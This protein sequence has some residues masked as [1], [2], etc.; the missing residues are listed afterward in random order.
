M[1][2]GASATNGIINDVPLLPGL[3]A[4][5]LRTADDHGIEVL[6]YAFDHMTETMAP[7]LSQLD[8]LAIVS[9]HDFFHGPELTDL[10]TGDQRWE[11]P[12]LDEISS[13]ALDVIGKDP[14]AGHAVKIDS[15]AVRYFR[16]PSAL[17]KAAEQ[18]RRLPGLPVNLLARVRESDLVVW[19]T[20]QPLKGAGANQP[21]LSSELW[22]GAELGSD[23]STM[24]CL[25][26]FFSKF[27]PHKVQ[28][29]ALTTRAY[30]NALI[31]IANQGTVAYIRS[32]QARRPR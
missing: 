16:V 15:A 21:V 13:S 22:L 9:E 28:P 5:L 20:T 6:A 31:M 11:L 30:I 23:V 25:D 10:L 18:R 26:R 29:S 19:S 32:Q 8:K 24:L 7:L 14:H 3:D 1:R 12:G 4:Q 27:T 17:L 2:L